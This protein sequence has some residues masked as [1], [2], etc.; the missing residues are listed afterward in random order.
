MR[1][2]LIP[3]HSR[4]AIDEEAKDSQEQSQAQAAEVNREV[5]RTPGHRLVLWRQRNK[6]LRKGEQEATQPHQISRARLLSIVHAGRNTPPNP[7]STNQLQGNQQRKTLL[8]GLGPT[9][10]L[11]G[12]DP[13]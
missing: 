8:D 10:D 9:S 5:G 4:S 2:P 6:G 7:D 3:S 13:V 1:R 11:G 12:K